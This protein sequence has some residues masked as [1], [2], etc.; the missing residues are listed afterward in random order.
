M[1]LS[2]DR[3]SHISHLVLNALVQDRHV[4]ALQPEERLLREIKR[5]ITAELQFEDE[6]DAAARRTIQS[7]SRRVPEGSPEWDV[8]YRKYM[9]EEM[10]R[11]RKV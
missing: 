10:R 7:L 3:I 1:R 2:E 6:A 5:T 4:N 8:L 9:D 11:R